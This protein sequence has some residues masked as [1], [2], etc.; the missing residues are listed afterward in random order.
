M[1]TSGKIN[2]P[3]GKRVAVNIGVDFDGPS[4]WMGMYNQESPAYMARGEFGAEVAAPRVLKLLDKYNIKTSWCIPGHTVDTFPEITKSVVDHG[5]EIVHHGYAHENITPLTYEE[6]EKIM[7]MGLES[8]ANLGVKPRGYRSPAWNYSPN[9][10]SILEKYG[11]EYDSSLMGNDLYPYRPRPVE[12]HHDKANVFGPDSQLL[13]IPVS[14][15]LDDF[16]T[17]EFA[18]G[19]ADGLQSV[20]GVYDRWKAIFDYACDHE[21]GACFVLTTHPQTIGRGHMIVELEKLIQYM[22]SR[23][24]WF[25]TLAEIH[26]NFE[27]DK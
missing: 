11:F 27:Q 10:L 23:G 8:L 15:L 14:W 16:P 1:Q 21:E 19:M 25:A 7:T 4:V 18:P 22:D 20:S 5:H 6:E 13:E 17:Q 2:L 3:K 9:T 26:D 24:A 12:V